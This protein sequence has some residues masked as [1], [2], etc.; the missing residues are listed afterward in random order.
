[1]GGSLKLTFALV[2]GIKRLMDSSTFGAS[3]A[4]TLNAGSSQ[5]L[6]E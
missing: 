6:F 5:S 1:M 3:I 4:S 2:D